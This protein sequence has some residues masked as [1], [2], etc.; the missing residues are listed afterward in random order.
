[1]KIITILF[2]SIS[3]TF[4]YY[5]KNKYDLPSINKPILLSEFTHNN[6][7]GNPSALSDYHS[8]Y[9]NRIMYIRE[10]EKNNYFSFYLKSSNPNIA[11]IQIKNINL[12]LFIPKI[13]E[14]IGSNKNLK[15]IALTDREWNRQQVIFPKQSKQIEIIGGDGFE[16]K[17]LYSVELARNCLNAGLW[18]IL[19]YTK[20]NSQKKLYYQGWFEFPLGYYKKIFES[21]NKVSY[22]QYF[23]YLEHWSD[24]EGT[25]VDLSLLR[26]VK[27]DFVLESKF[28]SNE[29]SFFAGEQKR[30]LRTSVV[31]NKRKWGAYFKPPYNIQFA[32]FIPP[33]IYSLEELKDT[34]YWRFYHYNGA[35][36]KDVNI[37]NEEDTYQEIILNFSDNSNS[38][39]YKIIIGGFKVKDLPTKVSQEYPQSFYMPMGISVPPFYQTYEHLRLK[40]PYNTY[41]YSFI[42]DT[43]NKW[44]DHHRIGI[45]GPVMHRDI[46][47]PNIVHLYLLSYERH[48][49][50]GHYVLSIHQ[51]S[52]AYKINKSSERFL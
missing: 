51:K 36:L 17:K 18:E 42:L 30:K 34:E 16:K 20:E 28:R 40:P 23:Y 46:A 14:W 24:P 11:E 2:V 39:K 8:K 6:Y 47:D 25:I 31:I 49:L 1:M 50:I 27:K 21:I 38:S 12:E 19:L 52:T 43:E 35:V 7:P 37:N 32:S 48:S 44:L 45:D 13:P 41:Y 4:F 22:W 10:E 29:K 5:I 3:I 9:N 26:K 33:G 15:R